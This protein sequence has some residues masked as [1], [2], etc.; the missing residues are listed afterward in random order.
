M[1]TV[2]VSARAPPWPRGGTVESMDLSSFGQPGDATASGWSR[3]LGPR[4]SRFAV[5]V[6]RVWVEKYVSQF[7]RDDK[8]ELTA[9]TYHRNAWLA[10]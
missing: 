4:L 7:D 10:R 8:L 1:G 6:S 3:R 5:G 9:S 2:K